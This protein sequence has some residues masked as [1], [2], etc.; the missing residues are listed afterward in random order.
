MRSRDI[1]LV[2]ELQ[3]KPAG[4]EFGGYESFARQRAMP[5][6]ELVGGFLVALVEPLARDDAALFPPFVG[7]D[8]RAL[9]RRVEQD[10]GGVLVFLRLAQAGGGGKDPARVG[11]PFCL[12]LFARFH[13]V[14]PSGDGDAGVGEGQ[15]ILARFGGSG[16]RSRVFFAVE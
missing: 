15:I 1:R 3:G 6:H 5:R 14:R 10:F 2:E 16:E 11:T 4:V 12:E 9:R 7:V 13:G 8:E